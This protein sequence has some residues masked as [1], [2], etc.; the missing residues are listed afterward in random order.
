MKIMKR[1]HDSGGAP[2][3]LR[4][5]VSS[6]IELENQINIQVGEEITEKKLSY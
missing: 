3:F 2:P 5:V 1:E 4:G 6:S